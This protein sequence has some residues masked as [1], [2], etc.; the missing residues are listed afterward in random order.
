MKGKEITSRRLQGNVM[1]LDKSILVYSG[2]IEYGNRDT[3]VILMFSKAD[4]YVIH[5]D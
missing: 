5:E 4:L 2:N 3:D 1:G